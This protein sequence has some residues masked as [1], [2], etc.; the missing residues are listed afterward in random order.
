MSIY[1]LDSILK[2]YENDYL[3]IDYNHLFISSSIREEIWLL[4]RDDDSILLDKI[5]DQAQEF[6]ITEVDYDKDFDT[7]SGGQKAILGCILVIS[8][9]KS[10]NLKGIKLLLNNILESLSGDNRSILCNELQKICESNDVA[11]FTYKNGKIEKL[12]LE[13]GNKNGQI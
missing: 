11:F 7:Y 10:K 3:I 4:Q 9:I 8:M 1:D 5:R 12:F 6:S 13:N 2:K